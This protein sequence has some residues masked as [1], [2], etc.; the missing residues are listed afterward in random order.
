L[1]LTA[2]RHHRRIDSNRL[3]V[4]LGGMAQKS[5]HLRIRVTPPEKATL[6]RLAA[7]AGQDVSSYV[8]ARVLPPGQRRFEELLSIL[9]S[10]EDHRYALAE[11]NDLLTS[12]APADLR[13]AVAHA[14]LEHLS[15]FLQNYVAAM[16]EHAC[17]RQE[18]PAPQWTTRIAPLET[19]YFAAPLKSLR[20]HL[21]RASPVPF[22]RR[23]LFVDA[24]LGARV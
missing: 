6:E 3:P 10:D 22:K 16:V 18:V 2:G 8:L 20:L 24:S 9:G 12:L 5:P 11:L 4:H 17:Y 1:L 21:L 19:P 23:N 13:E 7:A 15:P 14:E